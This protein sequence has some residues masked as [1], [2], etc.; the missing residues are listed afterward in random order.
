MRLESDIYDEMVESLGD[1]FAVERLENA[2]KFGTPDVTVSMDN[3][4]IW[5]ELKRSLEHELRGTQ[6]AW[7]MKRAK[8]GCN[9]DAFIITMEGDNFIII[10]AYEA[11]SSGRPLEKC[12]HVTATKEELRAF[13]LFAFQH[14]LGVSI[15]D[16]STGEGVGDTGEPGDNSGAPKIH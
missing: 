3:R 13:F 4:T 9:N 10:W 14:L 11:A 12:T 15:Y 7:L 8:A 2:V 5:V 16:D 6:V 1:Y